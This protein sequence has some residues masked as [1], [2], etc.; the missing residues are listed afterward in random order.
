MRKIG[1]ITFHSAHNYGAVLQVYALQKKVDNSD[2]INLRNIYINSYY[3]IIKLYKGKNVL[4]LGKSII[5]NIYYYKRNKKRYQ[6]FEKFISSKLKLSNKYKNEDELKENFPKY[7]IYITGS[8]QVWNYEIANGLKDSYTLNF[9]DEK[10]KR[11]SYAASIG[12]AVIPKELVNEYKTKISKIDYISVREEN[13]KKVLQEIGIK[14]DIEVV[15]D[16]TLLLTKEEWNKEINELKNGIK[17]KYI[18]AYVI[19]NNEEYYKIVNELSRRTG[20]K[21]VHF[22]KNNKKYENSLRS[23]YTQGPLEFL[24]LIKN[25]EYVVATSFHACIFSILF[26][27]KFFIVPHLNTGSR[28]T[29]L[30]DKL[31]IK[32]RIFNTFEEFKNIDYNFETNYENVE[33]ILQ[34]EREKSMSFLKGAIEDE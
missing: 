33:K 4:K 31:Q 13:A 22:E 14:K 19:E 2:I 29:N 18:L 28:V 32:G 16:P 30:L 1:I 26:H 24:N 5:S 21:V 15:L 6:N 34:Q 10:I 3:K 8:D 9:G 11:I 20:L 23:A 7:D 25:A 17:E 12:N 27:K